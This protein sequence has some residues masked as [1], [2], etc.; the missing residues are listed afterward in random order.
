MFKLMAVSVV[1]RNVRAYYSGAASTHAGFEAIGKSQIAALET[2]AKICPSGA[3]DS[4]GLPVHF[5]LSG[6]QVHRRRLR[7]EAR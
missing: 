7:G 4:Y 1:G 3:V 6:G 2:P 5:E